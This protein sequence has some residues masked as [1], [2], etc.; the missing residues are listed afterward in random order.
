MPS[1]LEMTGSP[2]I[3][4]DPIRRDRLLALVHHALDAV[5]PAATTT[6]LAGSLVPDTGMVSMVAIGKAAPA[7]TRGAL[8]RVPSRRLGDVLVIS[9]HPESLP[10][11]AELLLGS[12]PV[13]DGASLRAG[14]RAL[15]VAAAAEGFVLFL[16]SGGGSAL[17]EVPA[18]GVDAAELATLYAAMLHSGAPIEAMNTVRIHLSDLKGG[19]LAEA[20]APGVGHATVVLSDVGSDPSLVASAPTIAADSTSAEAVDVLVRWNLWD[21]AG[22]TVRRRLGAGRPPV[23]MTPG[24]VMV[25]GDGRSAAEAAAEAARR[26]GMAVRVATTE[27]A[28]IA[29]EAA[30]DLVAHDGAEVLVAAGETTVEVRGS[31]LGGRNQEAALAVAI[32]IHGTA[33]AFVAFGTDG[34]DGPTDAAGAYVDGG[35]LDRMLA[36]GVDPAGALADNDSHRA[37]DAAGALIRTGPTGVN[38]AD[39]WLFDPGV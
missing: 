29:T 33:G 14:D 36:A 28:G 32:A 25:A 23:A 8:A 35:T 10:P 16:I 39:L 27:L 9:D 18:P 26:A 5:E 6:G 34:I 24:P 3:A 13:P 38:V 20:L 17:A 15:E 7:M 19:R 2:P 21:D 30:A 22:E 1:P 11:H 12:H 37:L 31:G 4:D